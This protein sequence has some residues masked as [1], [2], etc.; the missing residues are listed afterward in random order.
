MEDKQDT[1]ACL[2]QPGINQVNFKPHNVIG[3]NEFQ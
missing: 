1:P 3:C 2:F